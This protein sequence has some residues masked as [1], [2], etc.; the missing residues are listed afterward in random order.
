MLR[1]KIV[2]Y[3]LFITHVDVGSA[4]STVFLSISIFGKILWLYIVNTSETVCVCIIFSMFW[5]CAFLVIILTHYL[6]HCATT[7]YVTCIESEWSKSSNLWEQ[8]GMVCTHRYEVLLK[9]FSNLSV[10]ELHLDLIEY[11][12]L[13]SSPLKKVYTPWNLLSWVYLPSPVILL[14]FLHCVKSSTLQLDFSSWRKKSHRAKLGE[15]GEW[16]TIGILF[17]A[18]NSCTVTANDGISHDR[19]T[20]H[21]STTFLDVFSSYPRQLSIDITIEHCINKWGPRRN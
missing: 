6:S 18:K 7:F 9:S 14:E 13:Q 4:L 19:E 21:P 11:H 12:R 15:Y 1:K 20:N 10:N 2:H 3:V 5:G 8:I 17:Y 16:V